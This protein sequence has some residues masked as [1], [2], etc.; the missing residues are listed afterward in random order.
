MKRL[1]VIFFWF[2]LI[3]ISI[4]FTF[5]IIIP[6]FIAFDSYLPIISKS[7]EDSYGIKV[8]SKAM[9]V[10]TSWDL[11]IVVF[12]DKVDLKYVNNK[13]FAQINDLKLKLS[14]I[15]IIFNQFKIDKVSA[16]KLFLNLDI[17]KDG[18]LLLEKYSN[19]I[20]KTKKNS[21]FKLSKSMPEI[22]LKK[23]RVS[24][25][26]G[27]NNYS[28]KGKNLN[29]S[30]FILNK[31]IKLKTQ[32]DLFLNGRKQIVYN[33]ILVSQMTSQEDKKSYDFINIFHQLYK[34]DVNAVLNADLIV[35]NNFDIDG[36][37]SLDK[38]FFT[39]GGKSFPASDLNL[40]L[41]GSS[42][43]IIS[44]FYPDTNS[45]AFISGSMNYGKHKE[46]NLKVITDKL[47]IEN[48]MFITNNIL[49]LSGK[50][51]LEQITAD[52]DL[53]A[54][55]SI[56]SDFKKVRS[57]GYI[58]VKN[59]NITHKSNNLSL[60]SLDADID[61]SK[62]SLKIINSFAKFNSQPIKITG[63]IDKKANADIKISANQLPLKEI[64]LASGQKQILNENEILTGIVNV[65]AFFKGS[66]KSLRP[67]IAI[68]AKDFSLKN[69][70]TS[71][72]ITVPEV[73]LN[74]DKNML[75]KAEV[76]GL[77]VLIP[78]F[79]LIHTDKIRLDFDGKNINIAPS[80]LYINKLRT[81][82]S[83][84]IS[85]LNS[86]PYFNS[87]SLNIPNQLSVPIEGYA[88]SKILLKGNLKLMGDLNKPKIEGELG[89]PLI[90]IPTLSTVL[91]NTTIQF[92]N[93]W[94]I[95]SPQI[96]IKNSLM[97]FNAQINKDFSNGLVL[98]N[99]DFKSDNL[100]L[101]TLMPILN[102]LPKSNSGMKLKILNGKSLVT[103][104][105]VGEIV[106]SNIS[107]N[108]SLISN[109]LNIKNLTAEAYNG[110]IGGN[111]DYDLGHQNIILNFQ[112][113]GL[114]ANP[115]ISALTKRDDDINGKL[116]FD[117]NL[118][119][120][121]SSIKDL[122]NRLRGNLNFIISNGQ[123]GIL[124]KFEHLLY[125]QNILSN[126]VLKATLNV[127]VKAITVK[128]TGVYKYMKGKITFSDGWAN[129]DWIKSSGPSM[130]L[131]IKGRYYISESLANLTILGRIADD[132][133]KILGPIG[134]FSMGKAISSIPKLGD[135]T[136][137]LANQFTTNPNYEN[138]S[139]IPFLTPK[140][141]FETKEFKVIIS[142]D[143]QK[144]SA[145]KSFKWLT[146]SKIN[147]PQINIYKPS[148]GKKTEIPDFI[149]KLPD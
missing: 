51:Y 78:E 56:K 120:N 69:K 149:K 75:I 58:K 85:G 62:D 10:Q 79:P 30:D 3:L 123:M 102:N 116:D 126:N 12:A 110:K 22:A 136:S 36:K 143:I 54:D 91:E 105:R 77:K 147:Q 26:E 48:V 100:N 9:K 111:I 145:V 44:N 131:Y 1:K 46:I 52:G 49:K 104:F 64:L 41:K 72:K 89:M 121:V 96:Q 31:K 83:G 81:D 108:I 27:Q 97:S 47:K 130:S 137:N 13:K 99:V 135:I 113:R 114:S 4:Y 14:L 63:V 7:I 146:S 20:N 19:Q 95:I 29:I 68:S 42:V 141:N 25:I 82:L 21:G 6:R 92:N 132:V 32:G 148:T 133:V 74:L 60:N 33:I 98:K 138:I 127:I 139:E 125:A 17:N 88:N 18:N 128:N 67:E 117:G 76:K 134:E 87:L 142:G 24:L 66:L 34:Y 11:S 122:L 94:K 57:S 93:D 129:I 8:Q 106:A 59:A 101:N 15:P 50:N 45:K 118:S 70:K 65:N 28:F 39:I 71:I 112:G 86:H 73:I 103:D 109:V 23:Y 124:G 40:N 43:K 35:K 119:M 115:A 55:F 38:V 84:K 144:Q 107:S 16:E 2:L 80:Y 5:L 61:F 90:A 37:I 53:K 140:T